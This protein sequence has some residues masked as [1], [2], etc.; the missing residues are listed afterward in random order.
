MTSNIH[1]VILLAKAANSLFHTGENNF[2]RSMGIL[3]CSTYYFFVLQW[4]LCSP[5][6]NLGFCYCINKTHTHMHM[7]T[8][9]KGLSLNLNSPL[10][11]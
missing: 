8:V 3:G 10:A 6:L 4:C 5:L 7:Q 1:K 2:K 9:M 11:E